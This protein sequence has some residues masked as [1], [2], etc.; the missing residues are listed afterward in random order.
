MNIPLTP[1]YFLSSPVIIKV[2]LLSSAESIIPI[3]LERCTWRA[4]IGSSNHY[5]LKDVKRALNRSA[6]KLLLRLFGVST[7]DHMTIPRRH[8]SP[9]F[10]FY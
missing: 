10:R 8:F 6:L 3:D 2:I 1:A 5:N 7:L 4:E 9:W